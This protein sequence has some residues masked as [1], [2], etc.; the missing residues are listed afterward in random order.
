[1]S[2]YNQ[3]IRAIAKENGVKLWEIAERLNIADGNFSRRLRRELSAEQKAQIIEI[4]KSIA[5]QRGEL[6]DSMYSLEQCILSYEQE[7][8]RL[9]SVAVDYRN[10]ANE[11]RLHSS[12]YQKFRNKALLYEH[13]AHEKLQEA[14]ILRERAK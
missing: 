7:A 13:L 10:K 8:R 6:A 14:K 5:A 9:A 2:P 1:M 3:D 11:Y 4:I 12:E